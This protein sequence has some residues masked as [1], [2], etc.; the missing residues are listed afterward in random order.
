MRTS[1]DDFAVVEHEDRG[2]TPDRGEPV[3]DDKGRPAHEEPLERFLNERF[4]LR[5]EL[6]GGLNRSA[7]GQAAAPG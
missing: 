1:L 5:V 4:G 3:R 6:R 2:R 7:S